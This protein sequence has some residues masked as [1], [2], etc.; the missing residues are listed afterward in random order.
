MGASMMSKNKVNEILEE[1]SGE[2]ECWECWH[3]HQRDGGR[4]EGCDCQTCQMQRMY[5]RLV[6]IAEG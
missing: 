5:T 6:E 4:V 2:L 3:E 1:V